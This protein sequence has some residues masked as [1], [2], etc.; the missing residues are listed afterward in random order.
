MEY[1]AQTIFLFAVLFV[2]LLSGSVVYS[3]VG[4]GYKATPLRCFAVGVGLWVLLVVLSTVFLPV[5]ILT[6]WWIYVGLT[7]FFLFTLPK[8]DQKETLS[9]AFFGQVLVSVLILLPVFY[10]LQN[11]QMHL[12]QEFAVYAKATYSIAEAKAI[13]TDL[14]SFPLAYQLAIV[15]VSFFT[16][17]QDSIFACF[18]FAILAFV[19]CEF[20]RNSG[21]KIVKNNIAFP[22]VVAFTL[23]FFLNPFAEHYLTMSADPFIFIA[24]IGFAFAEYIFRAGHLPKNLAAL[25][26]AILLALL[27]FSSTQGLLLAIS[28]FVTLTIRYIMQA[29]TLNHKQILGYFVMPLVAVCF[30]FIWQYY[31]AT[32]GLGYLLVDLDKLNKESITLVYNAVTILFKQHMLEAGYIAVILAL[33]LY[34]FRNFKTADDLIVDS[35]LLKSVFWISIVYLFVGLPMFFAQYDYIARASY[36]LGFTS[37]ALLQFIILMPVGRII[38]ENT[39]KLDIHIAGIFKLTIVVALVVLFVMNRNIFM[40]QQNYRIYN[41]EQ[42]SQYI[43]KTLPE[44]STVAII[45]MKKTSKFYKF[46]LDYKNNGIKYI[47]INTDD[48]PKGIK[49]SYKEFKHYNVDYVLL[50]APNNLLVK[51]LEH[52]LDPSFTYLYKIEKEGFVLVKKFENKLYKDTN[53]IIK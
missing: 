25:P 29:S 18:N 9:W 4:E 40:Q 52:N 2:Y 5:S 46:V 37:V 20:V 27:V 44:K 11:D 21:V 48:L 30:A 22:L 8:S 32:K 19:A 7:A 16:K 1:I 50:H 15:P 28:L 14:L 38:K 13:T 23:L 39:D 41:V 49:Q 35:L 6:L 45:D 3:F 47:S 33:G 43:E 36:S 31:L 34:S 10:F 26:P 42:I 53:I 51:S 12:W 17:I 24:A